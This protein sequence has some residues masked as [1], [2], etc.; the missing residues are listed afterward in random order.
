MTSR[1]STL[2]IVVFRL[3]VD[4]SDCVLLLRHDK[5]G[6]WGLVGG[7]IEPG[8]SAD[9]AALRETEEELV[10]LRVGHDLAIE[11]LPH[12]PLEWGPVSSRSAGGHATVYHATYYAAVFRSNPEPA[13][14]AIHNRNLVFIPVKALDPHAWPSNVSDVLARYAHAHRVAEEVPRGWRA[15]IRSDAC[16]IA[17]LSEARDGA[18]S[19]RTA[20]DRLLSQPI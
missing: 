9:E 3:L 20:L 13:L 16:G 1:R 10:P 2:S 4:D 19:V 14:A 11:R 5:W 6:D 18:E 17:R 12:D 8:E 15:S 7:H